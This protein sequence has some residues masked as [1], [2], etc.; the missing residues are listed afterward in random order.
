VFWQQYLSHNHEAHEDHE[1]QEGTNG[2]LTTFVIFVAFVVKK[3]RPY[4]KGIGSSSRAILVAT[5]AAYS[6][7]RSFVF[8][9]VKR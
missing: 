6:F 1:A 5:G 8:F 3:K 4:L 2:V 7:A 9:L